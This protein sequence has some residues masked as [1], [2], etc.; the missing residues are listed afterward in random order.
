VTDELTAP[1][2]LTIRFR[3]KRPFPLL[4]DALG[5]AGSSICAIMPER[6][7]ETDPF[8]QITEMVGS[9]PYRFKADERVVAA[10][11]VN[12]RNPAYVPRFDGVASFTAGPKIAYFDRVEW[13]VLPDAATAAAA[14]QAGEVDWWEAPTP[15]LLPLRRKRELAVSVQD[16]TGYIGTLRFNQLQPPFDNAALRQ[17]VLGAISQAD[18][19][20]AA[21][22]TDPASWRDGVGYFCPGTAMASTAGMQALTSPRDLDRVR[23]AVVTAGYKGER[24]VVPVPADFPGLQALGDVGADLLKKVGFTVDYQ[25]SDWGSILQ[26]LQK[27]EPVDQGGWS[28]FHTYWSGLDQLNPAVNSSLRGNGRAAGRGWPT[29]ARLE[30]LRNDWLAADD[31]TSQQHIATEIQLQALWTCPTSR[32]GRCLPRRPI[33]PT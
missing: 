27:T 22:G 15:D 21:A 10:L 5:K 1:D 31:L 25:A 4:P 26:R 9:G 17:A 23:R 7:A 24:V 2:D 11:M 20:T 6:L 12:E 19:M 13:H 3:L 14:L 8:K 28:L 32:L 30:A 18:F 16:R 33:A 29:S